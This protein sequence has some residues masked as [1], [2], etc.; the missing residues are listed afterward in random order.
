MSNGSF[1]ALNGSLQVIKIGR[2]LSDAP[3]ITI[4]IQ[5]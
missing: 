3:C 4:F 5:L 1:I 2:T